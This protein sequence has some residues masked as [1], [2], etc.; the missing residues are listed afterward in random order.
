MGSVVRCKIT[1]ILGNRE[2]GEDI[3]LHLSAN[4]KTVS[5]ASFD[6]TDMT[7]MALLRPGIAIKTTVSKVK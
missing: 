4:S 2:A 3:S 5:Q 6:V 7:N 1:K